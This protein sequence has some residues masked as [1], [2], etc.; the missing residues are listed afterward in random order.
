M[1]KIRFRVDRSG[2]KDG[3]EL[4]LLDVLAEKR[5]RFRKRRTFRP[6]RAPFKIHPRAFKRAGIHGALHALRAYGRG[7]E[8][9]ERSGGEA[10]YFPF[11]CVQNEKRAIARLKKRLSA[12]DFYDAESRF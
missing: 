7:A 10:E 4:T 11:L 5:G 9:A 2:R 3:N 6:A 1:H 8:S 12:S